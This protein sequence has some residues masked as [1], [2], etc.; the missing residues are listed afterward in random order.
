MRRA[1]PSHSALGPSLYCFKKDTDTEPKTIYY[2]TDWTV[3]AVESKKVRRLSCPA[4]RC[5]AGVAQLTLLAAR[6]SD[7]S[8]PRAPDHPGGGAAVRLG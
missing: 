2:L 3:Q 8:N 7:P 4:L 5:V 6:E 1:P